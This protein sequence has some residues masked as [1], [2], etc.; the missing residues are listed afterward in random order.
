MKWLV[1]LH[2]LG[3]SVWLGGHLVLSIGFLPRALARKDISI[4]THFEQH[5][6][7]VGIPALLLQVVTGLWMATIYVPFSEWLSLATPHHRL[8]WVK[9]G[10][11][12]ATIGLAVHAR[13]F[14]IP[15]FSLARLPVLALHILLVTV[16][17]LALLVAGLS[18]RFN[19]V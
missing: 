5:Y 6:E 8:L 18:F 16:F 3:A 4:I 9:L 15:R 11:L 12:L 7:Q 19:Y 17:A 14:L 13:F 2:V 10:L 1:L